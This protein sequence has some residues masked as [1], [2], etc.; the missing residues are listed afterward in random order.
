MLGDS[1]SRA[2]A[3]NFA[4]QWL[5]IRNLTA[6][7]PDPKP[8]P[9]YDDALRAAMMRETTLFFEH[10]PKIAACRVREEKGEAAI[11]EVVAL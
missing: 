1:N 7:A 4:G 2:L 6:I 11:A 10:D 5:Q 9:Q 8:F 3:D